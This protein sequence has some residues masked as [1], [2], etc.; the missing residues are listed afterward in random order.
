MHPIAVE[1]EN[2]EVQGNKRRGNQRFPEAL[3]GEGNADQNAEGDGHL[4]RVAVALLN[5]LSYL[6]ARLGP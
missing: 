5:S 4:N 6:V 1:D 3:L 2:R